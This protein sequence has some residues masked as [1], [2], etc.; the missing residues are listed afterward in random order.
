VNL[1]FLQA[2]YESIAEKQKTIIS[3]PSL[4]YLGSTIDQQAKEKSAA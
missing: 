1:S 3:C 4:V 2:D